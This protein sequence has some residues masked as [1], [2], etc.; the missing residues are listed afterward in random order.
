MFKTGALSVT[1]EDV[2]E[3]RDEESVGKEKSS[4]ERGNSIMFFGARLTKSLQKTKIWQTKVFPRNQPVLSLVLSLDTAFKQQRLKSWQPLLT[5]KTV[6]PTF[7][8]VGLIFIPIGVAL[9]IAS[10]KVLLL[11][12]AGDSSPAGL[13]QLQYCWSH[14][15][16]PRP[17]H[18]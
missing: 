17:L 2:M 16:N 1:L 3:W 5:P 18:R 7:F 15:F 4:L 13:H 6:L 14:V 8:I 11:L 9:Y 12:N 10:S